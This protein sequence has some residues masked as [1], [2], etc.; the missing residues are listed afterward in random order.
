MN[1]KDLKMVRVIELSGDPNYRLAVMQMLLQR[2]HSASAA[3][4][5]CVCLVRRHRIPPFHYC[6]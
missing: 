2:D 4:E 1:G 3:Q 5:L 6:F